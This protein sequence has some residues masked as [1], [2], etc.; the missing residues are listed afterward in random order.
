MQKPPTVLLDVRL[1][2]FGF[3]NNFR[4][5]I[6][7]DWSKLAQVYEQFVQDKHGYVLRSEQNWQHWLSDCHLD[8]AWVYILEHERQPEGYISYYLS[9]G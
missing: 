5:T 1:P 8:G 2:Y 6:K 7:Q 3:D 4:N 9:W